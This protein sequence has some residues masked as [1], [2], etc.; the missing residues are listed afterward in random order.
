M[1]ENNTGLYWEFI[2]QNFPNYT[3]SDKISISND[4]SLW[5]ENEKDELPEGWTIQ[6]L[7]NNEVDIFRTALIEY[8]TKQK[9][10]E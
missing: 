9:V 2:E 10:K 1:S 4:F 7:I 6:E 8:I 3:S 5:I